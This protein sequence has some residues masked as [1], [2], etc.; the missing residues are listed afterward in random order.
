MF[1]YFKSIW[2]GSEV[3]PLTNV[4]FFILLLLFFFRIYCY[5]TIGSTQVLSEQESCKDLC[6]D[7]LKLLFKYGGKVYMRVKQDNQ[8]L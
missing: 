8:G 6:C 3:K 4:I 7:M 2:P 5:K 1:W